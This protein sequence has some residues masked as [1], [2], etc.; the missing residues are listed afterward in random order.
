MSTLVNKSF[1]T[2]LL[3]ILLLVIGVVSVHYGFYLQVMIYVKNAGLFA[4]SGAFT[5]WLAVYMLFERVPLLYGSGIIPNNFEQFKSTI[6]SMILDNFFNEENFEEFS[7]EF[8]LPAVN[9]TV[10][11]D[12]IDGDEFF[13][14]V[15]TV[16]EASAFGKTISMFGG[17]KLLEQLR[18]PFNQEITRKIHEVVTKIDW[19]DVLNSHTSYEMFRPKIESMIDTKLTEITSEHV[20]EIVATM[21]KTHLGWLVVWGG[22]FGGLL[23]VLSTLIIL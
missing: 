20:K 16:I 17:R 21:I 5:N 11:V 2:N 15:I 12:Q 13:E 10:I 19:S 18:N 8:P 22:I 14:S 4:L 9:S 23:G 6:R 1:I 7:H 3:S